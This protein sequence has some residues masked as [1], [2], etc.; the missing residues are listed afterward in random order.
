MSWRNN[1]IWIETGAS[2]LTLAGIAA[3]STTV[4]GSCLYLASLVFWFWISFR[5]QLW[6]LMP[7]NV[8]TLAI[9]VFNLWRAL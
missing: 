8:A 6:G 4:A 2:V 7:L 5:K 9:S 1:D 3:G